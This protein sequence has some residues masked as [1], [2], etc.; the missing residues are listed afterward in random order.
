MSDTP[1]ASVKRLHLA[2]WEG[3]SVLAA[4]GA[5]LAIDSKW[6]TVRGYFNHPKYQPDL[7]RCKN[8]KR[9]Q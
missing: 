1:K 7:E 4:C 6:T 2:Y 9:A 8:C 5:R 3:N